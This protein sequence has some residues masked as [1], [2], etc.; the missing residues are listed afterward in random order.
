MK[1]LSILSIFP[2]DFQKAAKPSQNKRS[3]IKQFRE[4]GQLLPVPHFVQEC[5]QNHLLLQEIMHLL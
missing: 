5:P 2:P 1:T 4:S 3:V